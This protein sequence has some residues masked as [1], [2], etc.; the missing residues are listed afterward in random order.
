MRPGSPSALLLLGQSPFDPASGAA[1]SMQTLA[2]WLARA[3][4]TVRALSTNASES[5]GLPGGLSPD[6]LA[7]CG[8]QG[9]AASTGHAVFHA[10]AHGVDWHWLPTTRQHSWEQEVGVP[11]DACLAEL[12][13]HRR[14]D[15]VLTFG[16][17]P[18]DRR[19]RR[20]C[21][22]AGARV[23]FALHNQAFA[24]RPLKDVDRLLAPSDF[25]ARAYREA[26]HDEVEVLPLPIDTDELSC[27]DHEPLCVVFANP[28]PLKGL[29]LVARLAE[30]LVHRRPDIPLLVAGGRGSTHG[31]MAQVQALGVTFDAAPNLLL[32]P[33]GLPPRELFRLARVCL[34]PS[35]VAESGGRM[36]AEAQCVGAV[37]IV[38]DQGALPDTIGRGGLVLPLPPTLMRAPLQPVSV[39]DAAPWLAAIESLVDSPAFFE[40]HRQQAVLNS[41]RFTAPEGVPR[42]DHWMRQVL[43]ASRGTDFDRPPHHN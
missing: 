2:R 40:Q 22:R 21:R 15:L 41:R 4:W 26:G 20:M 34:M 31:F 29:M 23:V 16:D 10:R 6:D 24:G 7:A 36:A 1:R 30:R 14:P 42:L 25:L 35:I 11:Y 38:S 3:G 17:D 33:Q 32:A 9:R 27:D 28:E 37:P 39:D 12:L 43:H 19:R 5:P 18:G 13:R 8:L